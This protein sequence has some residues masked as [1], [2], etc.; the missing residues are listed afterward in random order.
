MSSDELSRG[1]EEDHGDPMRSAPFERSNQQAMSNA[2]RAPTLRLL[3][4]HLAKRT[5]TTA[6]VEQRDASND[7]DRGRRHPEVAAPRW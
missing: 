7:L 2:M 5:L 3:H 1:T 4:E 6:E